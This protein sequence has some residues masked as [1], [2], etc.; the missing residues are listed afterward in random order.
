[1]A[2]AKGNNRAKSS[3][4]QIA[5][6]HVQHSDWGWKAGI[7]VVLSAVFIVGYYSTNSSGTSRKSDGDL[8]G[9][10]S[11]RGVRGSLLWDPS[12]NI[13]LQG[14]EREYP[15]VQ[16]LT[17]LSPKEIQSK[18]SLLTDG[19]G[20]WEDGM[21]PEEAADLAYSILSEEANRGSRD[22]I[23]QMRKKVAAGEPL[24]KWQNEFL[25][26]ASSAMTDLS[27]SR[28]LRADAARAL[29]ASGTS[30]S[31]SAL[32]DSAESFNDASAG[33]DA[34]PFNQALKDAQLSDESVS[35]IGDKLNSSREEQNGGEP[36][37]VLD[38][39]LTE[40]MISA[41]TRDGSLAAA[42]AIYEHMQNSEHAEDYYQIGIGLASMTPQPDAI[43]FLQDLMEQK[44]EF[45]HLALKSILN[46]GEAGLDQ[47]FAFLETADPRADYELLHNAVDHVKFPPGKSWESVQSYLEKKRNSASS[48]LVAE[49]ARE[50]IHEK[51]LDLPNHN[52][53]Y[54]FS[55]NF[56]DG[57]IFPDEGSDS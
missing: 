35:L 55:D 4:H 8:L 49:F 10:S 34:T 29:A 12:K 45:S 13:S 48:P 27:L 54:V 23:N 3:K 37:E 42:E 32:I 57:I 16:D 22:L 17:K 6:S 19:A 30:S 53:E 18:V 31:I 43:P 24:P 44:N 38:D 56:L 28:D 21:S 25:K 5:N 2:A 47:V 36:E 11:N 14:G 9:N 33:R 7:A 39:S 1:M 52:K 26:R 41:L 40:A 50:I 51:E 20:R 15:P 46:S